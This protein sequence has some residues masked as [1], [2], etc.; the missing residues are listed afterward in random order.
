MHGPTPYAVDGTIEVVSDINPSA[1]EVGLGCLIAFTG[2]AVSVKGCVL[3]QS[4]WRTALPLRVISG[5]G[6][7]CG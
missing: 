3:A 1:V 2:S 5:K 4:E 7:R 6:R